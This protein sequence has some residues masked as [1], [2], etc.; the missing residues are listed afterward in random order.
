MRRAAFRQAG[1]TA[2][3]GLG[4]RT[5]V[6]AALYRPLHHGLSQRP[7]PTSGDALRRQPLHLL[8]RPVAVDGVGLARAHLLLRPM[9]GIPAFFIDFRLDQL[10]EAAFFPLH[11]RRPKP[12]VFQRRLKQHGGKQAGAFL[13]HLLPFQRIA[14]IDAGQA[15]DQRL[16]LPHPPDIRRDPGAVQPVEPAVQGG[17]IRIGRAAAAQ[18][19][20]QNSVSRRRLLP[21]R[22]QQ[23]RRH[24]SRLE[25]AVPQTEAADPR[26]GG[27]AFRL[28]GQILLCR[29]AITRNAAAPLLGNSITVRVKRNASK[30]YWMRSATSDILSCQYS[31]IFQSW[32]E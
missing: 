26:S 23:R 17:K 22:Q 31:R 12:A 30:S 1:E 8:H 2:A 7:P 9:P 16:G 14:V 24:P 19:K 25:A 32:E 6:A 4:H 21:Q 10:L 20:G 27:K 11:I 3:D 18:Q 15:E 28:Q 5:A 29:A 13:R